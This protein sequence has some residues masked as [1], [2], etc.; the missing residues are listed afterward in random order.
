MDIK[1]FCNK[2]LKGKTVITKFKSNS[3]LL[4]LKYFLNLILNES[5]S[6]KLFSFLKISSR[7]LVPI[8]SNLLILSIQTLRH[9]VNNVCDGYNLVLTH[10][11]GNVSNCIFRKKEHFIVLS[12]HLIFKFQ[13]KFEVDL[14]LNI[15]RFDDEEYIQEVINIYLDICQLNQ[16]IEF[17]MFIDYFSLI[18][19]NSFM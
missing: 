12:N 1:E 11:N 4:E 6:S 3:D 16:S 18:D 17:I 19:T 5:N 8:Y 7:K 9:K 14:K 2:F 10:Q 15:D 13:S